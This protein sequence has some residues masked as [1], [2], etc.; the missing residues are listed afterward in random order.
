MKYADVAENVR[1]LLEDLPSQDEFIYELLLAYGKPKASITRLKQGT[2]N[3]SKVPGEVLW[4]KEVWFKVVDGDLFAAI[5]GLKTAKGTKTHNPQKLESLLH[6]FFG[7]ACLNVDVFDKK[8]KRC[9]PR[10]WFIAPLEVIEEAINLIITG[11]I[12]NY[13]YEANSKLIRTKQF[14]AG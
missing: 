11:E 7:N 13:K 2:Y 14:D 1:L 5:E 4:K 3:Q 10:E 9:T 12:I 8:G 6:T